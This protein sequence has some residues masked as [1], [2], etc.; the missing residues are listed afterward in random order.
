MNKVESIKAR[1]RE[2]EITKNTPGWKLFSEYLNNREIALMRSM[3]K[4]TIEKLS[5]VRGSLKE[6][7]GIKT[8]LKLE[9]LEGQ[10]ILDAFHEAEDKL[11]LQNF[12]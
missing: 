11:E 9:L 12:E 2:I 8:W 7:D 4:C 10:Q 6:I 1:K 3:R 5:E